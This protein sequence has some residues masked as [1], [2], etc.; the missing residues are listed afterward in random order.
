[1]WTHN[2]NPHT[3]PG[4]AGILETMPR[5]KFLKQGKDWDTQDT[6]FIRY[7]AEGDAFTMVA[8]LHESLALMAQITDASHTEGWI[9]WHHVWSPVQGKGI[10]PYEVGPAKK[11]AQPGAGPQR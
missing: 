1:M 7:H 10:Q 2:Q 6:F 11:T 3:A 8:I 4:V 9:A 5:E